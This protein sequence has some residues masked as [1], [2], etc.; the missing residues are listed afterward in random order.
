MDGQRSNVE[1]R[2][3]APFGMMAAF[4]DAIYRAKGKNYGA[5]AARLV[6]WIETY[7]PRPART[8]L[9]V[10]CGTGEHL[11]HL[12]G[13][14]ACA[15][16]DHHAG[17]LDV[18]RAK[19]PADVG[20]HRADMRTFALDARFDVVTS[21]FAAVGYLA[22]TP[23]L[24]ATIGAMA[25]HLTGG[26]V[27]LLEP[28]LTPDRVQPPQASMLVAEVDGRRVERHTDAVLDGGALLITFRHRIDAAPDEMVERHRIRLFERADYARAFARAGLRLVHE[29]WPAFGTGLY[30]AV[31]D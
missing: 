6:E 18:A 28:P 10:G 11:A 25:A 30:V 9:D 1:Q 12:H 17:M 22:E 4:Y 7:G 13:R 16:L 23:D 8:L 15:G 20:L 29:A 21:L 24:E 5:E 3:R 14:F 31:R 26:G 2:A 19:L 27:L